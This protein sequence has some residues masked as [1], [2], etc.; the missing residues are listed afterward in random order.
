MPSPRWPSRA[1]VSCSVTRRPEQEFG[2]AVAAGDW[3]GDDAEHAPAERTDESGNIGANRRM[4]GVVAHNAFL[5]LRRSGFE[6]RFDQGDDLGAMTDQLERRRQH[7]FQR[8]EA[9]IDGGK[10]WRDAECRRC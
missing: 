1:M 2:I 4:H 10:I 7:Q 6:L 9:D 8:D 5:Y 3:R